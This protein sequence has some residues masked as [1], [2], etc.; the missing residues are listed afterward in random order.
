MFK[1]LVWEL[2]EVSFPYRK[3]EFS[4]EGKF[5]TCIR[6]PT[7]EK[8]GRF[9][10]WEN[11]IFQCGKLVFLNTPTSMSNETHHISLV[12]FNIGNLSFHMLEMKGHFRLSNVW[13]SLYNKDAKKVSKLR[14][15]HSLW[16]IFREMFSYK[17]LSILI[18]V[19]RVK[20]SEKWHMLDLSQIIKLK[21]MVRCKYQF[22]KE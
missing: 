17:T 22:I 20:L 9:L 13:K 14:E 7:W 21:D 19:R 4:H 1:A 2:E 6:D 5:S 18:F 3:I 12:A 8:L 15:F 10:V 16:G 11:S